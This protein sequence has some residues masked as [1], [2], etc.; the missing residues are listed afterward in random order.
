MRQFI[1]AP[2]IKDIADSALF[3]LYG[4]EAKRQNPKESIMVKW[5][6]HKARLS[7]STDGSLLNSFEQDIF[8]A[9]GPTEGRSKGAALNRALSQYQNQFDNGLMG[10]WVDFFDFLKSAEGKPD[11]ADL[12]W[13]RLLARPEKFCQFFETDKRYM[14]NGFRNQALISKALADRSVDTLKPIIILKEDFEKLLD[15]DFDGDPSNERNYKFEKTNFVLNKIRSLKSLTSIITPQKKIGYI[16]SKNTEWKGDE[17]TEDQISKYGLTRQ[18]LTH[19][20]PKPVWLV[21]D[22]KWMLSPNQAMKLD[23]LLALRN[24][25]EPSM[26]GGLDNAVGAANHFVKTSSE[27]LAVRLTSGNVEGYKPLEDAI[28]FNSNALKDNPWIGLANYANMLSNSTCHLNGRDYQKNDSKISNLESLHNLV[29]SHNAVMKMYHYI[30]DLNLGYLSPDEE[31]DFEIYQREL[32]VK[33]NEVTPK[34]MDHFV[35]E[36]GL[37]FKSIE[38]FLKGVSETQQ[39]LNTGSLDGVLITHQERTK[40]LKDNVKQHYNPALQEDECANN[41]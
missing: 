18:E 40:A 1:P 17:P 22:M 25:E 29:I 6:D 13:L 30:Q 36:T 9:L 8:N 33:F 12:K 31:R 28:V 14:M 34:V 24:R 37:S 20:V 27:M 10:L 4:L 26:F 32:S 21:D 16:T 7:A 3:Y 39:L 35:T 15:F 38:Q 11:Q 2:V 23:E 19:F 5:Y 41:I